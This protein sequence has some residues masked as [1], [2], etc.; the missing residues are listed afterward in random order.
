[1]KVKEERKVKSAEKR[2][3]KKLDGQRGK[4]GLRC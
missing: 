2:S 1:M 4:I 3:G